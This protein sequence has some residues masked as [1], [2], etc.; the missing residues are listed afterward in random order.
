[1][2]H[3]CAARSTPPIELIAINKKMLDILQKQLNEGYAN[4]ND[5]ALQE[6][7]LAQVK[8][9][10]PPLRKALAIQNRDLLAALLGVYPAKSRG[11]LSNS[12]I[13]ICRMIFRSACRRS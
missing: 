13:C 1:M 2:R 11:R 9:T 5:V 3:P 4:R 10:L 8:A 6:A 12:P 7:A